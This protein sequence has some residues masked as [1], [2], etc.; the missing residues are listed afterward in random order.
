[1]ANDN[2][3]KETNSSNSTKGG[4][5]SN[6]TNG[7]ID[8]TSPFYL[9]PSDGPQLTISPIVLRGDNYNEWA[10]SIRNN[11]RAKN[12]LG[13][14]DGTVTKPEKGTPEAP[15]WITVNSTLVAWIYA[16]LDSTLHSSVTHTDDVIDIWT[17]LRERFSI[18][19]G[20][21][22]HELKSQLTDCKQRGQSVVVYY[23]H[24]KKIWDELAGYSTIPPCKCEAA[25]VYAKELE[26]AKVHDFLV[27][28][29]SVPFGNMVSNVLMLDPL[30]SLNTVFAKA[31]TEE[32]RYHVART[33]DGKIDNV[34]F[35]AHG[36]VRGRGGSSQK[37]GERNDNKLVCSH[38]GR[39]GHEQDSC[40]KLIGF[41]EW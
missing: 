34:G 12:K 14:L 9:H 26:T 30:P 32:R 38:C 27:G 25:S 6:T 13:F 35:A 28:L 8:V 24:L 31:I 21:R 41:L 5:S 33:N 29:D 19:N 11:F 18:G 2:D 22:I 3:K 40:F 36:G 37:V 15:F 4:N 20:P 23:G 7:V 10:R 1:M 17:E 39:P 16:T